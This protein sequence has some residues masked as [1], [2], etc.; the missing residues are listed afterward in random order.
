MHILFALIS[1]IIDSYF[2]KEESMVLTAS[3]SRGE[4]PLAFSLF[5]VQTSTQGTR[6]LAQHAQVVILGQTI[7]AQWVGPCK[8]L[9]APVGTVGTK[10][11]AED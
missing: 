3:V 4:S 9:A 5:Q 10:Q 7:V 1:L 6:S 2:Y 11:G 8:S